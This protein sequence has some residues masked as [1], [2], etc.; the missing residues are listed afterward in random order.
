MDNRQTPWGCY[1]FRNPY[2]HYEKRGKSLDCI[3]SYCSS[4]DK[5]DE[6]VYLF[7]GCLPQIEFPFN[8]LLME[9]ISHNHHLIK[10]M[11]KIKNPFLKSHTSYYLYN[12]AY[13]P[14]P[15]KHVFL[16]S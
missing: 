2:T 9:N 7:N 13:R 3:A 12:F 10:H 8:Y 11:M 5:I 16:I 14:F 1:I 4:Y 15:S 6:F